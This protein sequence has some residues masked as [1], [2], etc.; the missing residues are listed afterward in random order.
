MSNATDQPQAPQ[1]RYVELTLG[2]LLLL[3]A[4]VTALVCNKF[5]E[6]DTRE[7]LRDEST[8]ITR[9][10]RDAV[11]ALTAWHATLQEQAGRVS[12]SELYRLF[13][14]EAN[15]LGA[16]RAARINNLEAPVPPDDTALATLADQVPMMRNVLLDF[17]NYTGF[18]DARIVNV[19]GLNLLTALSRPAPMTPGQFAIVRQAIDNNKCALAPVRGTVSGLMLDFADPLPALL[20]DEEN[21]KP[22]A[23]LLLSTMASGEL[24]RILSAENRARPKAVL[25]LVQHNG[26]QWEVVRGQ[27]VRPLPPEAQATFG[28]QK[29][30]ELPFA[31][32]AS[33]A[34]NKPAYSLGL[35]VPGQ[36]AFMVADMPAELVDNALQGHLRRLILVGV[37]SWLAF[38][39]LVGLLWWFVWE[40]PRHATALRFR[41]MYLDNQRQKQLLDSINASL[42]LGL[43]MTDDQ[44][45]V[46]VC[47]KAMADIVQCAEAD[48]VTGKALIMFF[49]EKSAKLL[50]DGIHTVLRERHSTSIEVTHAQ[51]D[52]K[53][54]LYRANLFPFV[55]PDQGHVTG[56][57]G[58]LKDITEFR[59]RAQQQQQR[60]A[61]TMS[62]F[63]RAI[64]SVDP[65]LS[66][67][68]RSMKA[69]GE[70]VCRHMPQLTDHDIST[71]T[72]AAELSQ[73]GKINLPREL[74]HKEGAFTDEERRRIREVPREAFNLLNDVEFELPVAEAVYTMNEKLDGT[75]YP[76]GLVGAA[77]SIHARVLAVLNAFCAMISPRSYR[78]GMDFA[79]ALRIL[80][81]DPGL[82]TTV[83]TA[84]REVLDSEQGREILPMLLH[85]NK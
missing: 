37:L 15:A 19:E 76:R 74:L 42:E 25:S 46:Q 69:L 14:K 72:T 49:G 23:A 44:G 39:L 71:I 29:D 65:Y 85:R 2:A 52:G 84:L 5:H 20:S 8:A 1:S 73:V 12:S 68:S 75:G 82:D 78:K 66:G 83:V 64:E 77:I 35:A 56:V 3:A 16:Q 60:Q 70:L 53:E 11:A 38:A 54:R 33:L 24:G 28:Q 45:V 40:R 67:H 18:S 57:V 47:N 55:E 48:S 32:R 27:E 51:V 34:D 22:E 31:L 79:S 81:E 59:R 61:K 36:K 58:T 62:A 10:V 50:L 21:S 41:E 30:N 13:A 26:E 4:L 7:Y 63:L 43:F 9:D 80:S 17:M 6:A